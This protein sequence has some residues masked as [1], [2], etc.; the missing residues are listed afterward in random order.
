MSANAVAA[1]AATA[2]PLIALE[3]PAWQPQPC[4][5]WQ[6]VADIA[7]AVAALPEAPARVFLAIGRQSLAPFA[8]R[9]QHHYLLRLVDPPEAPLPLPNTSVVLARGPFDVAGDTALLRDHAITHIVAKNAGGTGAEAKLAAARALRLPVILIDR[10]ALP[11]RK[12]AASVAEVM[13]WLGHSV[14]D[15]GV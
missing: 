9:P 2:T 13:G 6:R 15:R 3:R 8:A 14:T 12:L 4:D 1:C 7:A 10:P 11:S 5:N